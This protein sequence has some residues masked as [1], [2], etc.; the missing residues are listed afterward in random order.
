MLVDLFARIDNFIVRLE[1]YKDI[2]PNHAMMDMIV[3]IMVE[4]ISILSIA[5]A[6]IKQRRRSER[7]ASNLSLLSQISLGKYLN[8]LLG[9]NDIEDALKRLDTL[10]QEEAR[11]AI[12]EVLKVTHMMDDKIRLLID[13]A[14]KCSVSHVG[15]PELFMFLAITQQSM[16]QAGEEKCSSYLN[17][18]LVGSR[19]QLFL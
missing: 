14:R 18:S 19:S 15:Y 3:K 5:T 17:L 1:S 9:K 2:P 11:M 6:E 4:V 12:A 7:I 8:R 13:G 10:T 16:D